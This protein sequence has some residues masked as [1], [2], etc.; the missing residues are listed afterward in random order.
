MFLSLVRYTH[1]NIIIMFFLY[2]TVLYTAF[3]YTSLQ[4]LKSPKRMII[5]CD[6]EII[7]CACRYTPIELHITIA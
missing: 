3:Y 4:K 2:K 1:F 6:T 5:I 7:L